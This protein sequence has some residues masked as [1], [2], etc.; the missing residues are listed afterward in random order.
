MA[1]Q[2]ILKLEQSERSVNNYGRSA[3]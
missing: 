1:S 3:N 2:E